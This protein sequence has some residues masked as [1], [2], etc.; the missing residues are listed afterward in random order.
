MMFALELKKTKR[1]GFFLHF[2]QA[3]WRLLRFP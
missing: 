2:L 1:T 3:P